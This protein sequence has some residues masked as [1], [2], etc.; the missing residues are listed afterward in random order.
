MLADSLGELLEDG[1]VLLRGRVVRTVHGAAEGLQLV[2]DLNRE[3]ERILAGFGLRLNERTFESFDLFVQRVGGRDDVLGF[4]VGSEALLEPFELIV[5]V[6]HFVDG[7]VRFAKA[8]ADLETQIKL[9]FQ[10]GFRN[11]DAGSSLIS[12]GAV[13]SLPAIVRRA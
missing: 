4:V 8:I 11:R 2:G 3:V 6:A 13:Y 7:L 1:V 9:L 5:N 10:I 12:M